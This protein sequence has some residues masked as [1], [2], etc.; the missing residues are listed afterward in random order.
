MVK[1][2]FFSFDLTNEIL[3]V[4]SIIKNLLMLTVYK[5]LKPNQLIGLTSFILFKQNQDRKKG[6]EEGGKHK[7]ANFMH[8]IWGTKMH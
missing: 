8:L 2:K 4:S 6:K 3:L 1:F 7:Y 5:S